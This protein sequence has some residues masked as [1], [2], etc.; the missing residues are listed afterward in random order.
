MP[1]VEQESIFEAINK[2]CLGYTNLFKCRECDEFINL[3]NY[4]KVCAYRFCPWCG[5]KDSE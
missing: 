4:A 5:K 2:D 1:D 3:M